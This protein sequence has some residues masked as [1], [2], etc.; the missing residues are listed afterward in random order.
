MSE[1]KSFNTKAKNDMQIIDEIESSIEA[2]SQKISGLKIKIENEW[3]SIKDFIPFA[4][5]L[6]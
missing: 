4:T 1:R 5:Q 2:K 3:V 6:K